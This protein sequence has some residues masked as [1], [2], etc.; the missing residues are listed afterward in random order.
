[1]VLVDGTGIPLGILLAPANKS[2]SQLAEETLNQV[3]VPRS[4][5]GRPRKRPKRIIADKA[6][7]SRGL[8][9]RMKQRGIDLISPHR[10]NRKDLFQDGRKLRRY[11]KR[12]IVER[13]IAWLFNFRRLFVRQERHTHMFRAMIRVACAMIVLRR[14]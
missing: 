1:M 13:T 5:R 12:W 2:E 10:S 4:R 6:Y 3:S 8:W 11:K 14:F 7:D 9:E